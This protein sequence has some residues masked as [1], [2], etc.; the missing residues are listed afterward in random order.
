MTKLAQL[1]SSVGLQVEPLPKIVLTAFDSQI[2]STSKERLIPETNLSK[3]DQK[4]VSTLL[5]F[6]RDGVK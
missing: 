6:Q 2:K 1:S 3:V 4:L 5:P